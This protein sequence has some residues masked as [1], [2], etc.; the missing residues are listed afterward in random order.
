M[1]QLK[2]ALERAVLAALKHKELNIRSLAAHTGLSITTARKYAE[3]MTKSGKLIESP[4]G[5]Q[6]VFRRNKQ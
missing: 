3:A 2:P 1:P 4:Q 5:L 6:R